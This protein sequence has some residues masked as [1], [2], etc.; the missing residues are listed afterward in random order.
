MQYSSLLETKLEQCRKEH[1]GLID[2]Y[3][4]LRPDSPPVMED[5]PD[6]DFNHSDNENDIAERMRV[7]QV[8]Q[9][10]TEAISLLTYTMTA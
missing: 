4:H 5:E 9:S 3:L 6:F 10:S 1:G 7:F 2:D 8:S